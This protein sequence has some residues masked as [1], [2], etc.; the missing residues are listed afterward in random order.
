MQKI[1]DIIKDSNYNFSLFDR[2][3]VDELEQKIILK[4][5]KPYVVCAIRDKEIV[6]KP[7]EVIRQLFKLYPFVKTVIQ[8]QLGGFGIS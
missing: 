4:D 5:G 2:A 3:L 1:L 7:E 8:G 6:L